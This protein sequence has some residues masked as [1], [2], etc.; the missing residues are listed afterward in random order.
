MVIGLGVF[1]TTAK[2]NLRSHGTLV[3]NI[4]VATEISDVI[5]KESVTS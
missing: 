5:I 3:S 4:I 1:V 2:R